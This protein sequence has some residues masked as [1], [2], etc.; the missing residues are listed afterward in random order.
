MKALENLRINTRILLI[1]A[2]SISAML[3]LGSA[4]IYQQ[5][6]QMIDSRIAT[7][8]NITETAVGVAERLHDHE[9]KGEM[10]H[11]EAIARFRDAIYGMWYENHTN[12]L[13]VWTLDG[14]PIAHPAKP[15]L[16]GKSLIDLKDKNGVP[17]ARLLAENSQ[18]PGGKPVHYVWPKP[19]SDTPMPKISYSLAFMPWKIFVGTGIYTDDVDSLFKKEV[20]FA[21][22]I[23]AIALA[24]IAVLSTVIARSLTRPISSLQNAMMRVAD[25]DTNLT[26][27]FT[28]NKAEIGDFARALDTFKAQTQEAARMRQ[29]RDD[30]ER[31]IQEEQV[32]ARN[33]MADGFQADVGS[34]TESVSGT[35]GE[36]VH[37]M[38]GMQE[39]AER[40]QHQAQTAADL[41]RRA[42]DNVNTVAAAAE[43]LTASIQEISRQTSEASRIAA[44][45][46]AKA[47]DTNRSVERLETSAR[48]IGEVVA[49]ISDIAEQTNLLALN[50][51]IEAARAGDAGKGFAV[52]ASEVKNLATQTA[53]A[54]DEIS[55]KINAIQDETTQAVT[56]I[57]AIRQVV[58]Q[59]NQNGASVAAA[60]EEQGVA[61]QEIVRNV[62]EAADGA[63]RVVIEVTSLHEAANEAGTYAEKVTA[64][65]GS[66]GEATTQLKSRSEN[67][68]S[69]IRAASA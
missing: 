57:T 25:G 21:L 34:I 41:T 20:A 16:E 58:E 27:A 26:V 69:G 49:L 17:L 44:D 13:F 52:V 31:R 10:S 12:Y 53:K 24:F 30:M 35:A 29:E 51:T 33:Q 66:V 38:H 7:V 32:A 60:I 1:V 50:A 64:L 15:T 8:R 3:A 42:A 28:D 45:A 40:T 65:A 39:I 62:Q 14:T 56:A 18:I 48:E 59:L 6:V 36:M 47:E 23:A 9:Q 19:G 67:F 11:D 5:Y 22:G 37:S 2:L 46:V 63:S 54:T 61:T 55:A 68:V 4:L 43:E